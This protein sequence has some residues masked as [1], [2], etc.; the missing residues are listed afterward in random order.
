MSDGLV[1]SPFLERHG[2]AVVHWAL[3]IEEARRWGG[4]GIA[5][6][7]ETSVFARWHSDPDV[8]PYVLCSGEVP[9]GYGELWVDVDEQEVELAR[10]IIRPASR[11][12]GIGRRLVTLLWERAT[13]TGFPYAFMRVF[14]ENGVAIACYRNA[15]FSPVPESDQQQYN[16]GQPLD[17]VWLQRPLTS[18]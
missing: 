10:I 13:L 6:P 16:R 5:W 14:P 15:G 2:T 7:V 18:F 4:P 1:I 17:Y 12:Q 9:I 8:Q 3:S 11:G